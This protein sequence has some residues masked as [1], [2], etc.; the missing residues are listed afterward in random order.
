[1]DD[2]TLKRLRWRCRRGMRE[3]DLVL[4]RFLDLDYPTMDTD[5]QRAFDALLDTP[6]PE[7]YA[8]L[9]QRTAPP[10]AELAGLIAR[11]Q[12]HREPR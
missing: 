11:L 1:V 8:W 12:R 7:L 4:M 9:L 10:T 6:D 3:L 2:A 5:T